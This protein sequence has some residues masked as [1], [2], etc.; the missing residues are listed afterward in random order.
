MQCIDRVEQ[1][2]N[3][4]SHTKN[5][6]GV[7]KTGQL[8]GS[9][10]KQLGMN[11][12]I[13]TRTHIGNHLLYK[14]QHD[15]NA[16][17]FLL[18]G[19]LDTV[20]ASGDFDDFSSDD[21]WIYG[22]GVCDMKGG[23]VV[24]YSALETIYKKNI[25][26]KNIDFLLVSDE[27]TGSDDSKELSKKLA[28]D[29]EY[30]FVF[31]AAGVDGAVVVGRKG[32]GTFEIDITG[33][34]KHAGNH[35]HEGVDAN[36]EASHKLQELVALT[37]ISKNTTVNVGCVSGG[38]GANTI[39]PHAY[40]LFEVR[41]DRV[42]EKER[43]LSSIDCIVKNSYIEGTKCVLRGGIQREVMETSE[44]IISFVSAIEKVTNKTLKREKRGGVSDANI[45]SSCGVL[46]LDGLGPYGDGDHTH[47]E[48]ALKSSFISRI[49]LTKEILEYFIEHNKIIG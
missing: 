12:T 17:L 43:V 14:S 46:T 20:F 42:G 9:W 41:Y 36:L 24:A 38:I 13:Y 29:Y 37:D 47:K 15:K 30:C 4:N 49:E 27:E 1:L 5:K 25:S 7:D 39:S 44:K 22:P 48:R 34:A 10:L 35:Y 28:E 16:K 11:E 8:L 6:T 26:L 40:L 32:V 45:F 19:H 33:V 31:E 2:V 21:E 18:V 3:I 23:L